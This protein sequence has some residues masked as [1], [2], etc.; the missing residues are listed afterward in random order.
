LDIRIAVHSELDGQ[1]FNKAFANL[2]SIFDQK[3]EHLPWK[4][5]RPLTNGS[6][7]NQK[8][9]TMMIE[10]FLSCVIFKRQPA[11]KTRNS[12]QKKRQPISTV[13]CLQQQNPKSSLKTTQSK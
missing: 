4:N 5:Y 6:S 12:M 3:R 2:K 1:F 11:S 8:I 10:G 13:N 9:M 7:K